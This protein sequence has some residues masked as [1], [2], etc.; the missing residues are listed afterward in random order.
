[1]SIKSLV[2][3]LKAILEAEEL[4]WDDL[5]RKIAVGEVLPNALKVKEYMSLPEM[6]RP[7]V[8]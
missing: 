8:T 3:K 2:K 1:M 6:Q 7:V 4:E 5:A